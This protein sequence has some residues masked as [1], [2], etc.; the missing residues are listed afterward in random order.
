M[1]NGYEWQ[2]RKLEVT[3][4]RHIEKSAAARPATDSPSRKS[5]LPSTIGSTNITSSSSSSRVP[6]N[7]YPSESTS[8]YAPPA[9]TSATTNSTSQPP[10]IEHIPP[11]PPPPQSHYHQNMY[12][13]DPNV[14]PPPHLPPPPPPPMYTN[15]TLVGGP[16]AN[17]PTHGHNQIFVNNVSGSLVP[18][19]LNLYFFSLTHTH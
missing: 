5:Q 18:S 13:Y 9:S 11:P 3:E 14:P 1:F 16:A 6:E 17:L 2:G 19:M 7:T 15:M 4:E 8:N 10:A 12:R